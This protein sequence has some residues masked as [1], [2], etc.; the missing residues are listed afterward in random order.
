M[1]ISF[2]SDQLRFS[3]SFTDTLTAVVIPLFIFNLTGDAFWAGVSLFVEFSSRILASLLLSR[4]IHRFSEKTLIS[5]LGHLKTISFFIGLLALSQIIPWQFI[6]LISVAGQFFTGCLNVL[7]E[8]HSLKWSGC[9]VKG[10]TKYLKIDNFAMFASSLVSILT[11]NEFFL[12]VINFVFSIATSLM[13]YFKG[14]LLFSKENTAD[15]FVGHS[16]K[17]F[18]NKVPKPFLVAC[19]AE[20]AITIPLGILFCAYPFFIG[21]ALETTELEA[22]SYAFILILKTLFTILFLHFI[23]NKSSS[24]LLSGCIFLFVFSAVSLY[25]LNGYL[26][27][28]MT[29]L[30]GACVF[31]FYPFLVKIRQKHLRSDLKYSATAFS[32]ILKSISFIIAG[33]LITFKIDLKTL[34]SMTFL[35]SLAVLLMTYFWYKNQIYVDGKRPL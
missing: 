23:E 12:I 26:Y 31:S 14:H 29:F 18:L 9:Y 25:F 35:I 1:S 27:I 24:R 21:M 28:F 16:L 22:R 30:Y 7:Y 15:P 11:N 13:I 17:G 8:T 33:F 20:S 19:A 34:F 32:S 3:K 5:F 6:F 2:L 4:L 10:Y